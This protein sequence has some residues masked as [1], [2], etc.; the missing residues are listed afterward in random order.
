[1]SK[2]QLSYDEKR[3]ALVTQYGTDRGRKAESASWQAAYR[4]SRRKHGH[5][6]PVYLMPNGDVVRMST[7]RGTFS[8]TPAS[9]L[10][11]IGR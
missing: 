3:K 7:V 1:M 9:E 5:L 10:L 8:T 6:V 4:L 2:E 11:Q